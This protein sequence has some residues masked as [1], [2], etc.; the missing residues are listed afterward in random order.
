MLKCYLASPFASYIGSRED[1]VWA[2]ARSLLRLKGYL[3]PVL[4][5]DEVAQSDRPCIWSPLLQG[6]FIKWNRGGRWSERLALRWCL[7]C[8]EYKGFNTLV[9]ANTIPRTPGYGA[10]GMDDEETLARQLGYR[11]MTE[12]EA[13]GL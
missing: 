3:R 11:V 5:V 7:N 13:E 4:H 6:D 9:L 10:N 8:L 12:V 1:A 2:A